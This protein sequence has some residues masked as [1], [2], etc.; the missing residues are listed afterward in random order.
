LTLNLTMSI[1]SALLGA[2]IGSF[3]NVVIYRLPRG[4]SISNPRR[5]FCPRCGHMIAG[6]DNIPVISYVLLRGRCRHCRAPIS[7]Q[8]PLIELI[9]ALLFV[10]TYDIFIVS[11]WRVGVG[12][13]P[14][15][16]A[17]VVAH[18]ALWAGLLATAVMDLE[19]YHLDIRVTWAVALIGIVCN[20]FWTPDSSAGWIRP[21]PTTAAGVIAATIALAVTALYAIGR[22]WRLRGV[23]TEPEPDE[24]AVNAE[25]A[26]PEPA[27]AG[28]HAPVTSLLLIILGLG[29]L[30]GYLWWMN[31]PGT[32]ATGTAASAPNT[33]AIVR[34]ALVAV[35]LLVLTIAAASVPRAADEEIFEAIEAESISARRVALQEAAWLAP[36][37][38]VGIGAI[39]AWRHAFAGET[40]QADALLN[41]APVGQ[42]RPILG[43]ATGLTGWLIAGALGWAV[44]LVFTMVL[45]KEA[46]GTGDIH[47][48]AAAG[49]VAGWLVVV[50]GFFLSAPLALLGVLFFLL[51]RK[52]RAIQYG[53][54]LAL[55]FFLA[56]ATQD[57]IIDWLKIGWMLR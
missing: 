39:L 10:A 57:R 53:P 34:I 50:I 20:T 47:I 7:A 55:G 24:P 40:A 26:I 3:L 12:S 52:S 29:A 19:A 2:C 35:V 43:L 48:L 37:T 8:Y 33:S 22:T 21:G 23:D 38:L 41:W 4:L 56:A 17:I 51:R 14:Q 11:R 46:L 30:V 6:Y 16:G 49:A 13:W 18:W 15:D 54:W 31:S 25:P 32:A 28:R 9:T 45:G 36:A 44:R 5:S 42:W 27:P 1:F